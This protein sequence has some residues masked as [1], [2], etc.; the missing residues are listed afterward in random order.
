MARAQFDYCGHLSCTLLLQFTQMACLT[1]GAG[2][3]RGASPSHGMFAYFLS[4]LHRK[5]RKLGIMREDALAI[6]KILYSRGSRD[7]VEQYIR[8]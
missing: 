6:T 4:I 8:L 3:S 2:A 1:P 5:K 7:R